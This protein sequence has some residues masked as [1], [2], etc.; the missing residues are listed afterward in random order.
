MSGCAK[1][2]GKDI[3]YLSG[4]KDI[5]LTGRREALLT[6]LRGNKEEKDKLK[7]EKPD[8]F[9]HFNEIWQIREDHMYKSLPT[10]TFV[11][12]TGL[13]K[14]INCI[15]PKCK[16]DLQ[17]T[18]WFE[19][20]PPLSYFPI[21]IIDPAYHIGEDCTKCDGTCSGH[22]MAPEA[23]YK[24]YTDTKQQV[25]HRL[26]QPPSVMIKKAFEQS[27]LSKIPVD[28]TALV[29]EVLLSQDEI[30]I[31]LNHLEHVAKRRKIGAVKAAATRAARKA[32]ASAA[33]TAITAN[34]P[35]L[36][37]AAAN[38][39]AKSI[40]IS[41]TTVFAKAIGRKT[42]S[43]KATATRTARKA[44]VSTAA[45]TITANAP[46]IPMT[47]SSSSNAAQPNESPLLLSM[48][49]T[50]SSTIVSTKAVAR[51]KN[52][53][54][55][56]DAT[57]LALNTHASV[58]NAA[59]STASSSIS[60]VTSDEASDPHQQRSTFTTC[61]ETNAATIKNTPSRKST[62]ARCPESRIICLCEQEAYIDETVRCS[63]VDCALKWYH[64]SC[65]GLLRKPQNWRCFACNTTVNK[66]CICMQAEY[67]NMIVC[68]Q[69]RLKCHTSCVG[70][71][72]RIPEKWKC[73]R[74][75]QM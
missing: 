45:T 46:V 10:Y 69:C 42:N 41:K 51:P 54:N 28:I 75:R 34:A 6:Y 60:T 56:L 65:V 55:K 26:I 8:L 64:L 3:R 52:F 44:Q 68:S 31:W 58:S 62:T 57:R 18:Q 13:C 53:T 19:G 30:R 37:R 36:P 25:T 21:P 35:D 70:V 40:P 20:G 61:S 22:F 32:E 49:V 47:S 23:A 27:K 5:K 2:G 67:G 73:P 74:C 39:A 29:Q 17:P 24:H 72:K 63:A 11:L 59:R 38:D 66:T 9:K 14:N 71:T 1:F 43:A 12:Y 16:Q 15:H 33:A 7:I 4:N 50:A 48:P